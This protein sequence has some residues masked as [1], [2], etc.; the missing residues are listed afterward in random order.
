MY[1]THMYLAMECSACNKI[2][3]ECSCPK[4]NYYDSITK[5]LYKWPELQTLCNER[6]GLHKQ[7][8]QK[9]S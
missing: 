9:T 8:P 2:K 3:V 1:T 7:N 6:K 5:K 4:G